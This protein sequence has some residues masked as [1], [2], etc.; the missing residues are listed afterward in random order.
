MAMKSVN[1]YIV[2]KKILQFHTN[3]NIC[4]IAVVTWAEGYFLENRYIGYIRLYFKY[5]DTR[6]VNVR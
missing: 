5:R 4:Q 2:V 1:T 3:I 6:L